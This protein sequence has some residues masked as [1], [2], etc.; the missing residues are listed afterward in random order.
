[1]I[2]SSL[3][4]V[5]RELKFTE[6]QAYLRNTGWNRISTGRENIALFQKEMRGEFFE[7]ILPL[8]KDFADYSARVYD[9]INEIAVSER[10]DPFLV[11]TDLS[12]PPADIVRFRIVSRD[13]TGGTISFLDGF[14]LLENAKKALFTTACDIL[15]PEKYHRRLGLKGAQQFI[16][17][18]RLGQTGKGSFIASVICPFLNQTNDE[19]ALPLSIFSN[20]EELAGSF[21]RKVTVRLMDSLKTIKTSID[22]GEQNRLIDLDG[23]AIISA[24]FLESIL[25]LNPVQENSELE[26]TTSW[27]VFANTPNQ[28]PLSIKFSNDYIPVLENI[29]SKVKPPDDDIYD[30]FIGRVSQTKAD[31]DPHSRSE[32][33]IVLN[34]IMGNEEKV[35]KARVILDKPTYEMACEAHK[36]GQTVRV[37]GKLVSTSRSKIIEDPS[38]EI[39]H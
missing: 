13:T 6:I 19:R 30:V 32:G 18:C 31:P 2:A 14:N 16:E 25:D 21:T 39:V 1:M 7:A 17:A 29:I 15:K 20:S 33:E 12:L 28:P 11:L 22:N 3:L 5:I 23:E 34:Y 36:N 26:I 37:K 27:S 10:R 35:S 9:V 8:S 38:F 4:N 24:N